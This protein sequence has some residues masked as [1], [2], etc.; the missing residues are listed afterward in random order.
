[1]A[2]VDPQDV[3]RTFYMVAS[4][5]EERDAWVE[6]IEGNISAYIVSEGMLYGTLG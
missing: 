3:S 2:F 5:D 1:M 4:T 6:A